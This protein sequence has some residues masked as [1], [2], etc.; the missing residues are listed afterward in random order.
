MKIINALLHVFQPKSL[1]FQL[2]TRTMVILALLLLFIGIVQ[3]VVLQQFLYRSQVSSLESRIKALPLRAWEGIIRDRE[4]NRDFRGALNAFQERGITI[5]YIDQSGNLKSIMTPL[6]TQ[7][8][9]P[10][11][12]NVPQLSQSEYLKELDR[13][14]KSRDYQIVRDRNHHKQILIL[15]PLRPKNNQEGMIQVTYDTQP[16]DDMLMR[17]LWTY[18]LGALIALIAGAFTYLSTI[19]RTLV[20][21]S[22]IIDNVKLINAGNLNHRIPEQLGQE[23][24]LKLASSFNAMLE[25]IEDSF[26]SE[27]EAKESMRRFIAD[28]SHE[29]RTPL[30]S[31]HGF[32]EVLLRGAAKQ[33]EQLEQSLR[34]MYRESDRIN[35]LV[36]DLLLLS[37][38]DRKP[39]L[40]RV[41]GTLGNIVEEIEL[42]LRLI[43]GEREVYVHVVRDEEVELDSDRI[44]QVILNLFQNAVQHTD[45][46]RGI[47]HITIDGDTTFAQFSISDNG[48]GIHAEHL[49]HIFER[50]YREE[51]SRT[52]KTGGAGL[53]LSIVSSII[54]LHQGDIEVT[55]QVNVGSTFTVKLPIRS[56]D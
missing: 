21:L 26:A 30:T 33:P 9:V 44:K 49:P 3:F 32:L 4:P 13:V 18:L 17:A 19:R 29:L 35:K 27:K 22:R 52:R 14:R 36:H 53:G 10:S 45:P 31:I 5:S 40:H 34:S 16:I 56:N 24:M 41:R 47:I 42:Q 54:E 25:R 1:R 50:F 48:Q 8:E 37:K 39:T 11:V 55:S 20:P 38:F 46:Q 23:E 6:S 12:R 51:S 28:A 2:L 43:A 7:T 15:Y